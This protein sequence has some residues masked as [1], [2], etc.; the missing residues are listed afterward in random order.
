MKWMKDYECD[1]E[2][3]EIKFHRP[4]YRAVHAAKDIELGDIILYIP[5]YDMLIFKL[6]YTSPIIGKKLDHIED[7]KMRDHLAICVYLM[8][9][10]HKSKLG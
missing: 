7:E 3:V 8:F 10:L 5:Y 4:N 6:A 2:H 9:K 1:F